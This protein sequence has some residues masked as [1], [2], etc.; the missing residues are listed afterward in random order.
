MLQ[1]GARLFEDPVATLV[2][3]L[4]GGSGLGPSHESAVNTLVADLQWVHGGV[5]V[6]A[7][8]LASGVVR[9]LVGSV[10]VPALV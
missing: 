5:T 8:L 7:L 9:P 1:L 2:A 3:R 10:A 6:A 4:A